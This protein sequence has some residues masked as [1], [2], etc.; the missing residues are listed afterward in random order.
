MLTGVVFPQTEIG[1]DPTK[2]RD[3][4]QAAEQLGYSHILAYD[5]VLGAS[6]KNR[7]DWR[8]PYTSDT[9]FHEPLVLFAYLAGITQKVEFVTGVIILPQR[10]TALVAKQAAELDVVSGGRLRLGVGIGWNDVEYEGLNENF[11]NR[12]RRFE[13]QI[14]V[15]RLLWTQPILDFHGQYHNITEA[16]INPL[17]V[18]RPIPLWIGAN[19]AAGVERAG[20]IADGWFPQVPPDERGREM[21]GIF[22]AAAEQA[23]RDPNSLGIEARISLAQGGPDDWRQRYESWRDLGATH[24]SV[25]TMGMGLTSPDEHISA[26][27]RFKREVG[28]S[29]N[30]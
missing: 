4:A 11:R 13:E 8:G 7:P 26:I 27:E 22:R 2:V 10:Q 28:D 9:M 17:P 16:G 5:H 6:T 19:V 15:L 25:N 21:V 20:R 29:V 24:I 12:A 23:G 18:Q 1:D 14:E 30:S 3:Y